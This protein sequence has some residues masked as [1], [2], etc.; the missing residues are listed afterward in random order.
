MGCVEL[1]R[2]NGL[3][4]QSWGKVSVCVVSPTREDIPFKLIGKITSASCGVETANEEDAR[5]GLVLERDTNNF[6]FIFST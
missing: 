4:G 6:R 5:H 1:G 3:R 2:R